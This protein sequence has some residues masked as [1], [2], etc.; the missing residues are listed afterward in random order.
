LYDNHLHSKKKL[1]FQ[2]VR[3]TA[4]NDHVV[5]ESGKH[6]IAN[7]FKC[8][9]IYIQSSGRTY[10]FHMKESVVVSMGAMNDI[11]LKSL[12]TSN[13]HDSVQDKEII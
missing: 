12:A 5:C 10:T 9:G 2:R 13:C 3:K 1:V 4:V 11:N 7:S 8:M 6:Y